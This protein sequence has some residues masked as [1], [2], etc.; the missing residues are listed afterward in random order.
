MKIENKKEWK[1]EN[2][3]NKESKRL[4]KEFK[5]LMKI[6]DLEIHEWKE[7]KR[8]LEL[9]EWTK[10]YSIVFNRL[11]IYHINNTRFNIYE[12]E[13]RLNRLLLS[14]KKTK[15]IKEL[16]TILKLEIK[17]LKKELKV[18]EKNK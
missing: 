16:I 8:H 7:N 12:K 6:R 4:K 9:N 2:Y 10:K 3:F 15:Y 1:L 5:D 14:K 17:H 13:Y 11:N 18:Y